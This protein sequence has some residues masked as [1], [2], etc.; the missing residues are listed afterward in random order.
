MGEES[1]RGE[2][3]KGGRGRG[4]LR[5]CRA[6][7]I[8]FIDVMSTM[9]TCII[10]VALYKRIMNYVFCSIVVFLSS[11]AVTQLVVRPP[12]VVG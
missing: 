2:R 4:R 7:Y 8:T 11:I 6:E 1:Q 12:I 5:V 9:H 10:V 3:E